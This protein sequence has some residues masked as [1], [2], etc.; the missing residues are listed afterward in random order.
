MTIM[1]TWKSIEEIKHRME[2]AFWDPR[3]TR[4][5]DPMM[6]SGFPT[7]QLGKFVTHITYGSTRK[8]EYTSTG[9]KWIKAVNIVSTGITSHNVQYIEEGGP[10]DA[11]R[12]RLQ[13]GDLLI[14]RS[15]KGSIGKTAIWHKDMGVASASQD[16]DL[17][18]LEGINPYYTLAFL[19]SAFGQIQIER[20]EA[21]VS[22]M[23]HLRFDDIKNLQIAVIPSAI[24]S[25]VEERCRQMLRVHDTAMEDKAQGNESEYLDKLSYAE[26]LLQDL[27]A[28]VENVIKAGPQ[29]QLAEEQS[30]ESHGQ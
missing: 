24:Q 4:V 21:G 15:G 16:T 28:H 23:T 11:P 1:Y 27:I 25:S 14:V 19:K 6:R 22:R 9:V 7:E 2:P 30:E 20:L 10:L 3:Y 13:V 8:I 18:R 29:S 5:L 26:Q 17:V 12:S